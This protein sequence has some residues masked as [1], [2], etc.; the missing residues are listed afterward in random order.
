MDERQVASVTVT[1]A[2]ETPSADLVPSGRGLEAFLNDLIERQCRMLGAV[3]GTI[4]LRSSREQP[5]GGS[6]RFVSDPKFAWSNQD[7]RRLMEIAQRV[8]RENRALAEAMTSS[9]GLLTDR[10]EYQILA[11]PLRLAGQPMGASV[12]IVPADGTD[13]V[14]GDLAR[15]E[16]SAAVF[17]AYLWK[18]QA[19]TETQSKIQLK[20]TLDLLDRSTQGHNTQEMASLFAH[21]LQRRFG[22]QRVS[23]G[24]IRGQAIRLEAIGGSEH[25]DRRSELAEAVESAMEEC[26][27]QDIEIRYPQPDEADPSERRVVRA[28]ASLS[29][30]FGPTAIAS[31]PLRVDD[32]LV[33]VVIMERSADD[34]FNDATLALLR[35]ISEYLGPTIWTRRLA[36]RGVLAVS[37][38][39]FLDLAELTVGPEKTGAKLFALIALLLLALTI[40]I[41]VQDRVIS[42]GR[43]I[44]EERR[45]VSA[46]FVGQIEE[47]FVRAGEFVKQ[48]DLLVLLDT[49]ETRLQLAE[50]EASLITL[51]IEADSARAKFET[52][53]AHMKDAEI[54]GRKA[55]RDLL[56]FKLEQAEIRAP[57][58][59]YITQGRLED[60][61][62]EVVEPAKPLLEVAQLDS[63]EAIALVPESGVSRIEEGQ[64]GRLALTARPGEKLRFRVRSITPASEVFEQRNV[65][66]AEIELL[67]KPEWLRPGME[68]QARIAGERTNLFTIYT[69]PLVNA[70]RLRLW[71]T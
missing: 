60:L 69:R 49:R 2:P 54:E 47:V 46:P 63:I 70:L 68:G 21:E 10:P 50:L 36:D 15:L 33:G 57:I 5:S 9:T 6:A 4:V 32:G 22:C 41:P 48:G 39:R 27:D 23:I 35:L 62:G 34:P 25:L 42:D 66:R 7:S 40:V 37:R 55:D 19:L 30:R 13:D 43:I 44:A 11:T 64:E 8:A 12:C 51:Q 38:D 65:Y 59:G 71:W 56:L 3:S 53:V 52:A 67:D 16:M 28:H 45:Q 20:E 1:D 31:F 29:E 17:E 14:R 61:V 26:A 18:Q 24:L 58:D